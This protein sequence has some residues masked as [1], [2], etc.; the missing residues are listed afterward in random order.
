MSIVIF[1][2]EPVMLALLAKTLGAEGH[3][4]LGFANEVPNAWLQWADEPPTLFLID[5]HLSGADAMTLAAH[6]NDSGFGSIPKVA[7][8]GSPTLLR[9]AQ[10]SGLFRGILEK[11]F[12]KGD[13]LD[14]VHRCSQA[15]GG[16]H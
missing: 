3:R 10:Q 12:S 16:A 7:V 8:S 2:E 14:C 11:P 9:V 15:R 1:H 6:L 13:L 4:V 5:A